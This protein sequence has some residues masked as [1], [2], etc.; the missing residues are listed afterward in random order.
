MFKDLHFSYIWAL[1]ICIYLWTINQ[2]FNYQ[3]R[4][5]QI[6]LIIYSSLKRANWN[7][8]LGSAST[9]SAGS[10]RSGSGWLKED[11]N[12]VNNINRI[13]TLKSVK[14]SIYFSKLGKMVKKLINGGK[15]WK[16]TKKWWKMLI[17]KICK[18]MVKCW[19]MLVKTL[20]TICTDRLLHSGY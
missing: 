14:S 18:K 16:I 3:L 2:S 20:K 9:F 6:R 10:S 13:I 4:K 19:K 1:Y 11:H 7:S 17:F 15:C 5:I 12:A 8:K